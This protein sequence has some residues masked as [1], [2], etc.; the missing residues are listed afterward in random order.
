[1]NIFVRP[2]NPEIKVRNPATGHHVPSHGQI[3]E[4][5][6][7]WTRRILDGDLVRGDIP[8][9]GMGYLPHKKQK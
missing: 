4:E 8:T 9:D 5:S 6:S 3:V 1:M 2:A 7:Y